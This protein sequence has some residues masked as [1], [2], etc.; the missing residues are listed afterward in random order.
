MCFCQVKGTIDEVSKADAV[1][2]AAQTV[3]KTAEE[4]KKRVD[5]AAENIGKSGAFK[6]AT[7]GAATIKEEIEGHSLGGK[8]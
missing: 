1:R 5:A 2:K 4:A 3:G 8:V 6:K 7:D